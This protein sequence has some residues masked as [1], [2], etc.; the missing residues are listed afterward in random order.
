MSQLATRPEGQA[1]TTTR[2]DNEAVRRARFGQRMWAIV[3]GV[4]AGLLLIVLILL[5]SRGFQWFDAALIGYAVGTIFAFA[6]VT[7]KYMF[8]LMRPQTGRYFRRGWQLFFSVENFRKYFTLIPQ[9][10]FKGIL[11]QTFIRKRSYYRWI[12]HL[13]IFWGVILSLAITWPLTFGWLRFTQPLDGSGQYRMWVFGFP[14]FTFPPYSIIGFALYHALV[15]TAILLLIG[16]VRAF[17]RRF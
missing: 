1:Q 15:F 11:A 10:V 5:G 9:A 16:L 4:I 2:R 6:A 7:Y 13:C 8:W 3:A 12:M 14:L 17:H